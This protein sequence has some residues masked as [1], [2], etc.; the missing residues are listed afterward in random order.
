MIESQV[1]APLSKAHIFLC[2]GLNY[3]M[4]TAE[5]NVRHLLQSNVYADRADAHWG[6]SSDVHK[7][8]R[9]VKSHL[10]TAVADR[11]RCA[12]WSL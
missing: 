8:S 2:I 6:V 10:Y 4:H 12:C 9:C 3:K 1:L 11:L 5:S 7:T